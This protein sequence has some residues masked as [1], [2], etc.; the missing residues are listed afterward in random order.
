MK[1]KKSTVHDFHCRCL[2]IEKWRIYWWSLLI[3]R[4]KNSG[5]KTSEFEFWCYLLYSDGPKPKFFTLDSV[6]TYLI[7]IYCKL[8][9]LYLVNYCCV[10]HIQSTLPVWDLH[11]Q[12]TKRVPLRTLD[13]HLSLQKP[14]SMWIKVKVNETTSFYQYKHQKNILPQTVLFMKI[15]KMWTEKR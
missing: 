12:K 4:G 13:S 15:Q 6:S 11:T 3:R 8:H 1:K 9:S 5:R 14:C 10:V 2:Y 7:L